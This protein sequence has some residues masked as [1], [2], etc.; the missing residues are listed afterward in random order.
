[1][2]KGIKYIDGIMVIFKRLIKRIKMKITNKNN[3]LKII[4]IIIII[5][6]I[7]LSKMIKGLKMIMNIWDKNQRILVMISCSDKQNLSKLNNFLIFFT[8]IFP[9]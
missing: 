7:S 8:S 1:M 9:F 2:V 4:I 5:I 6:I 3:K